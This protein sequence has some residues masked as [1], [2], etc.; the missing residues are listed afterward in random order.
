M[1][2]QNSAEQNRPKV[3]L[4]LTYEDLKTFFLE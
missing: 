3:L 1:Y 4:I 2:N